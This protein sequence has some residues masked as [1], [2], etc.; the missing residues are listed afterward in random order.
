MAGP[1]PVALRAPPSPGA[2]RE[3]GASLPSDGRLARISFPVPGKVARPQ[4][5]T[6]GDRP[7]RAG[8]LGLAGPPPVALRAP[9]SPG[10][11]RE[12]GACLPSD[13]P[14]ARISFPVPGKVARPQAETDGDRPWRMRE[15]G[16]AGPPPVALRAPPSPRAGRETGARLPSDGP[17]ARIS[18]PDPGKVAR[19]QA[20]TDGDRPWR[21]REIGLAGPP[22]VA[23]RA[24]PSPVRGG[25]SE[26]IVFRAW[27]P[28]RPAGLR[29][30]G[31]L[32]A[33]PRSA[34]PCRPG[35]AA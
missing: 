6:D 5:E 30:R 22:P 20:E 8:A 14:L 13:G 26:P 34:R 23:L 29:H 32:A 11:G 7:C 18:F 19:P 3:T 35:A 28:R 31:R 33:E 9:P 24:P 1:P 17:L 16:L 25:R 4:A 15:I 21:M 2:G 12:T 27:A 10:A